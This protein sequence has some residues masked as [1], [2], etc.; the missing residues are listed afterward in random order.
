MDMLLF[1][2]QHGR[3]YGLGQGGEIG[4]SEANGLA[5]EGILISWHQLGGLA[6]VLAPWHLASGH[7][8]GCSAAVLGLESGIFGRLEARHA[9]FNG[10]EVPKYR[11]FGVCG[12]MK[13]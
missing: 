10:F 11:Y 8:L 12:T 4:L 1:W 2:Y 5:R 7:Q 6:G 9:D 13:T 3:F